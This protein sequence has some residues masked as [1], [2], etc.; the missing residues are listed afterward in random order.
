MS[1]PRILHKRNGLARFFNVSEPEIRGVIWSFLYFFFLLSSY[2]ILRL[3]RDE[4][5]I[6]GG[7]D[8]LQWL[9]TGTFLAMVI[10]VPV[11]AWL[12]SRYSRRTLLPVAYLFFIANLLCFY[13]LFQ[14]DRNAVYVAR[15]FFIW[16]SV[17]NLFAGSVFWS[18]IVDIFDTESAKRLFGIIAAGGSGGAI[19]GPLL[20]A[21][22]VGAI[23]VPNL[24]LV[25]SLLLALAL[26]CIG[27]LRRWS[28]SNSTESSPA[29]GGNVYEGL[30]RV[31]G[32]RYLLG[33]CGY[34][35]LYTTVATFLYFTQARIVE[36]E[37]D[38]GLTAR[39]N[40]HLWILR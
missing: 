7:V 16:L 33:I 9:F 29:L 19:V 13:G 12:A 39:K 11:F 8:Q 32:S 24:L 37:F 38:T 36:A 5:G 31:V 20:T 23:G 28:G 2:Y 17:F 3:V 4:M 6:R 26:L 25:A 27:I 34:I 14:L 1:K 18:F 35:L 22:L 30:L 21:S 15:A 10:A 40:L